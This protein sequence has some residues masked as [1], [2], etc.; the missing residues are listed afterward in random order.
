[1]FA[2]VS[3]GRAKAVYVE[4]FG[5]KKAFLYYIKQIDSILQSICLL[6]GHRGCQNVV[7]T[8]VTHSAAP[9]VPLFVLT[10]F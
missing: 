8:S 3:K 4:I 9:H 6:I 2:K 1:M 7:R 5:N 10:T